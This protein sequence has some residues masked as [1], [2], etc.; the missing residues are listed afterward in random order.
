MF[1]NGWMHFYWSVLYTSK[2]D[3]QQQFRLNKINEVKDYFVAEIKG[4]E[5]MSKRLSKY[6]AS[7]DYFDKFL[8][9]L[10]ATSGSISIASFATVVGAPVGIASARFNL[11]FTISTGIVEKLLKTMQNKKKK[12]NKI[13]LLARSR[14][15]SIISETLIIMKLVVKILWQLLTKKET[16]EN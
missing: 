9:V 15:E 2:L 16:I 12:H 14:L 1:K 7:C 11:A 10:S 5:L 3:D 8:I 6:I 4:T 13:V